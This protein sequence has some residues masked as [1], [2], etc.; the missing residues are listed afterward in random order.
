MVAPID[1]QSSPPMVH[2]ISLY[3]IACTTTTKIANPSSLKCDAR[4]PT[5]TIIP[6]AVKTRVRNPLHFADFIAKSSEAAGVASA[7]PAPVSPPEIALGRVASG[8]TD[9][10]APLL[11]LPPPRTVSR[12]LLVRSLLGTDDTPLAERIPSTAGEYDSTAVATVGRIIIFE[13]F[14]LYSYTS[15]YLIQSL[16]RIRKTIHAFYQNTELGVKRNLNFNQTVTASL[17]KVLG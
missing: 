13:N 3:I 12:T 7:S 17:L 6:A 1:P 11:M 16:R 2:V 4:A 9:T 8:T 5:D 10:D 14:I 15:P